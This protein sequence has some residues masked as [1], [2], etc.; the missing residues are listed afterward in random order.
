[1]TTDD[2]IEKAH[3]ELADHTCDWERRGKCGVCSYLAALRKWQQRK[4]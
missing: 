1:M 4:R 2:L 3:Q